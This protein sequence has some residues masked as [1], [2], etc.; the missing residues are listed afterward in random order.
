[1]NQLARWKFVLLVIAIFV[2]GAV[3]GGFL[4]KGEAQE[5]LGQMR[6]PQRWFVPAVDRWRKQLNLTS[7]QQEKIKPILQQMS[8]EF[9]NARSVY[10]REINL[11]LSRAQDRIKPLLGPDQQTQLQQIIDDRRQRIGE[12]VNPRPAKAQSD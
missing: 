10:L 8:D 5:T 6:D 1:M 2:A 12:W 9:S 3:T 7:E 4:T 11:I